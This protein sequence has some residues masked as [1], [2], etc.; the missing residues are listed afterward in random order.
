MNIEEATGYAQRHKDVYNNDFER[1]AD[2]YAADYAG[3]RP[4]RGISR[5][6]ALAA[7]SEED[8]K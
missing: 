3:Y 5:R 1:Y 4:N 2:L 8:T 6:P 7:Q